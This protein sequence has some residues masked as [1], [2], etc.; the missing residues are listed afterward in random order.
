MEKSITQTNYKVNRGCPVIPGS[1]DSVPLRA[2]AAPAAT[3]AR[4][5]WGRTGRAAGTAGSGARRGGQH[6]RAEAPDARVDPT[7]A[8]WGRPGTDSTGPARP[9]LAHAHGRP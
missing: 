6:G 8:A 5:R 4:L 2:T 1:T 7:G 9:C 3:R